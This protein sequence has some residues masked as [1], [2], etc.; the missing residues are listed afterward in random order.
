MILL[1]MMIQVFECIGLDVMSCLSRLSSVCVLAYGQSATG[2][3]HTMMGTDSE[4]GLVPRLCRELASTQPCDVTFSFLEIYNERV[5]DL[6]V[7][8]DPPLPFNSLPRRRGNARKDLRVRQ[9][10]TKGPYVQNLRRVA[11]NDVETLL[12]LV[13]EGGRRRRTAATRRN[14]SSSR[15]HALLELSTPKAT[16]HLADLAG[17]E[18]ASW[19]GCCG[20]RQKEGANINKSLVA[21][22]NVISALVSG[23]SGRG[24]FVPYRDSALTWLLKDCF[25]GG[26]CTFI[27]ATVSPSVACYG[28]SASTLRWSARARQLPPPR[29]TPPRTALLAHYNNLLAELS[30]HHIQYVPE[31]GKIFYEDRHWDLQSNNFNH[32]DENSKKAV[33]I[34]NLLDMLQLKADSDN[35]PE[36]IISPLA[37]SDELRNVNTNVNIANEITKEVDK[38]LA[39]TLERTRSGSELELVAP[40]RHKRRQ[41][42]S[43]EVLP[44]EKTSHDPS[45][46]QSQGQI[47]TDHIPKNPHVPILYDN[48]RAEIVASVTERL[49]SKLKKKEEATVSKVESIVDKK[50]MEPLSELKICTNARQRLM[51]LSQKA[52]RNKRR[53][54]IPAHTQTRRTVIRVKDQ[55]IDAQTDLESYAAREKS[56]YVVYRDAWTETNPMTPRCKDIA[57]G[58]KCGSLHLYD[59]STGTEAKQVVFKSAFMMT[60]DTVRSDR[61]TQTRVLPPPRRKRSMAINN[62]M[63]ADECIPTPIIHINISQKYIESESQSSEDDLEASTKTNQNQN[64]NNDTIFVCTTPDLLT[65]HS[66]IE[67]APTKDKELFA[68]QV[69]GN[70]NLSVRNE[71]ENI[72]DLT[73]TVTEDFPETDDLILPRVSVNCSSK[74]DQNEIKDIILGRNDN[75]YPYNIAISPLREKENKRIVKFNDDVT[76]PTVIKSLNA[77]GSDDGKTSNFIEVNSL[78]TNEPKNNETS[79]CSNIKH[80]NINALH[81]NKNISDTTSEKEYDDDTSS[82]AAN[83]SDSVASGKVD[84]DSFIWERRDYNDKTCSHKNRNTPVYKSS[85]KYRTAK[86]R[87][88][89]EFLGLEKEYLDGK[90]SRVSRSLNSDSTRDFSSSESVRVDEPQYNFLRSK[91]FFEDQYKKYNIQNDDYDQL[92]R[93][94]FDSCNS[95]ERSADKYE[96]YLGNYGRNSVRITEERTPKKY[97]QHLV[98]LR[99][100]VIKADS[101]ATESPN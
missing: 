96:M 101:D 69:N 3:T 89:K 93:Q 32:V 95:L 56:I 58:P 99:K 84:S 5:H 60:D 73:H 65:N 29:A 67:P 48:Q 92:E 27:I 68:I 70:Q 59:K 21:L 28:E 97:L 19:E 47:C 20:G 79:N 75:L 36:A 18:K 12:A 16:L 17:S 49:Y 66:A 7:G 82:H 6:L 53:I 76:C 1:M 74:V 39:P 35:N 46:R 22:S 52:L 11:V 81:Y 50:I 8:E 62:N 94:I 61:H 64:R 31:T 37:S 25:T 88:Y 13:S 4:P 63:K 55:G 100:E 51:D 10:P 72:S 42:R 57:I 9:H 44:I 85:T 91:Q 14:T 23:G 2:K 80:V 30:R 87:L 33:K 40:L 77:N 45:P 83:S 41:Y 86:T 78:K 38:L 15:S 26:A 43:Q 98:Q 90:K 71:I 54:G 34:G 24:R